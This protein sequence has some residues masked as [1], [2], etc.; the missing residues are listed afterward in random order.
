MRTGILF[1]LALSI[2]AVGILSGAEKPPKA[3]KTAKLGVKT[4]GVQIP[5]DLLKGEAEIPI[6]GGASA[7]VFT[8]DAIF[9]ST[10]VAVARIDPKTNKVSETFQ[11][12]KKPCGGMESAFDSIWVPDCESQM[13]H[14]LDPKTGKITASIGAGAGKAH[15]AIAASK[16]SV[17]AL[18]DDKTTLSRVDPKANTV[19]A[20]VR[21]PAGCD[22]I[23]FGEGALWV[24][25]PKESKVLRID[26]KTNL[27]VERIEVAS[28]PTSVDFGE[29]S[30]W[31]LCRLEGKVARIDP[32]T[33]KVSATIDLG[34]PDAEGRVAFGEGSV[35]VSAKQFPIS[36]IQPRTDSVVQQ[37]AGDGGGEIRTGLGSVWLANTK[38]GLV[39]RLDPKRISATLAE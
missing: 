30:V 8:R 14:R 12:F 17:W 9:A 26:P 15:T 37:F 20:E 23:A 6:E 22:S 31:V 32:K 36:R 11:G 10:P 24:T 19:V 2:T 4:P 16:D 27:V 18:T 5:L 29:G 21:L 34:I 33:N 39:W 7:L 13:L 3:A 25:C 38:Q 1:F 28:Q 35:W